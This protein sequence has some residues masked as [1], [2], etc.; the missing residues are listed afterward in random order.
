MHDRAIR[1]MLKW[2]KGQVRKG[3]GVPYIV[4]PIA[5]ATLLACNDFGSDVVAA[6]FCHDLLEDTECSQQEIEEQCNE[7][8]L[9]IVKTVTN[10]DIKNWREKKRRYIDQVRNGSD[11][12]KA[13]CCADK[14]HNLQSLLR[15][16]EEQGDA[17]WSAFNAPKEDK[18]WFDQSVLEMLQA[19]WQHPLI[20]VYEKLVHDLK[21]LVKN[22]TT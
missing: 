1:L 15:A 8:V 16:H 2:H 20:K 21:K 12:A 9:A 4:H 13:V 14:I 17:I 11:S 18:L 3:D 19:N 22:E 6:G 10:Q 5:V 7:H